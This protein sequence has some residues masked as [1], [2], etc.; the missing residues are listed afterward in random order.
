[1][2]LENPSSSSLLSNGYHSE[3]DTQ[4]FIQQLD[5]DLPCDIQEYVNCGTIFS[6]SEIFGLGKKNFHDALGSTRKCSLTLSS[7]DT[8]SLAESGYVSALVTEV[9]KGA[10]DAFQRKL[11]VLHCEPTRPLFVRH[12][13]LYPESLSEGE[14]SLRILQIRDDDGG[15]RALK[16]ARARFEEGSYTA[17]Y[18]ILRGLVLGGTS[19]GVDDSTTVKKDVVTSLKALFCWPTSRNQMDAQPPQSSKSVLQ[20]QVSLGEQQSPLNELFLELTNLDSIA[21]T[22]LSDLSSTMRVGNEGSTSFDMDEM[23][24]NL[25]AFKETVASFSMYN[26][27]NNNTTDRDQNEANKDGDDDNDDIEKPM[28]QILREKLVRSDHDFTDKLWLFLRS[29]VSTAS[30]SERG[31]HEMKF[32]LDDVI[33]DIVHGSLQPAVSPINTTRLAKLIRKMYTEES[34]E[35]KYPIKEKIMEF[36]SNDA[37]VVNL[38][39]EIATEKLRKDYYHYFVSNDLTITE[40]LEKMR[41]S[42]SAVGGKHQYQYQPGISNFNSTN[43][44]AND[45]AYLWKLHCCLELVATPTVY[46][47]LDHDSQRSLLKAAVDYY[48]HNAMR[49]TT[50]VFCLS[51]LPVYDTLSNVLNSCSARLPD[52]WKEG[53]LKT[54][55]RNIREV[56]I[57]C[58]DNS[59]VEEDFSNTSASV[60]S[61]YNNRDTAK[62]MK[63]GLIMDESAVELPN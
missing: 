44:Q 7:L 9:V 29:S 53:I 17:G 60:T 59:G 34:E 19:N 38:I 58:Q 26:N 15:G 22:T 49:S 14:R 39:V 3:D 32:Y 16:K 18:D 52:F 33:N 45:I 27:N 42:G 5:I 63:V 43:S 21:S 54:N 50:P 20:V 61:E 51:L 37:A 30:T 57:V 25:T 41:N 48:T 31:Y 4:N 56:C 23:Y 36:L 35:G 1:M 62:N 8:L 55:R 46:L 47:R 2:L 12:L 6:A 24:E 11:F 40:S 13:L 28:S 10:F